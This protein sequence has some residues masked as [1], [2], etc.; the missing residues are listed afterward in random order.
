M[1]DNTA[2]RTGAL[3]FTAAVLLAA[4]LL[5]AAQA[6]PPKKIIA[7]E[8]LLRIPVPAA[9]AG[10]PSA[11]DGTEL[12]EIVAGNG[13]AAPMARLVPA[14]QLPAGSG[15]ILT[16]IV[17]ALNTAVGTLAVGDFTVDYTPLLHDIAFAVPA[18]GS[19]AT[20]TARDGCDGSGN[21]DQHFVATTLEI[22]PNDG[23]TLTL[24]GIT[25][26]AR[27]GITGSAGPTLTGI[28]GSARKGITGSAG[29]TLTRITGSARKGITGSAGPTLTG[30][31]GSARGT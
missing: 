13:N 17:G 11:L 12:L 24:A 23:A 30:I 22:R 15:C 10:E 7:G 20:L 28:T 1:N 26:S 21:A 5:P 18:N 16:G 9:L 31:T 4:T 14:R 8:V 3:R 25:G 29:P 27:K 19:V 6:G 2:S